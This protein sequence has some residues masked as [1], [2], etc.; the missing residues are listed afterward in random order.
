MHEIWYKA[1]HAQNTWAAEGDNTNQDVAVEDIAAHAAAQLQKQSAK[2]SPAEQPPKVLSKKTKQGKEDII[3][4]GGFMVGQKL[5]AKTEVKV[6]ESVLFVT[7]D[8]GTV[9]GRSTKHPRKGMRV[10]SKQG[11]GSPTGRSFP[12][13]FSCTI[14]YTL[15]KKL[16]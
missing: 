11:S 16:A 6:E 14:S 7:G 9:T 8:V 2:A 10:R 13:G 5:V 15:H 4:P 12:K 1:A 3:V